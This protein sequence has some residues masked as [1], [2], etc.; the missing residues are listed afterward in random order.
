MY[1]SSR[2]MEYHTMTTTRTRARARS[3]QSTRYTHRGA[4]GRDRHSPGP[5]SPLL[6]LGP[7]TP[8]RADPVSGLV[9]SLEKGRDPSISAVR[10]RKVSLAPSVT[11][12]HPPLRRSQGAVEDGGWPLQR[13]ETPW[14]T[15]TRFAGHVFQQIAGFLGR[16]VIP[17]ASGHLGG[18]RPRHQS[19]L[20]LHT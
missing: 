18:R 6:I 13:G 16:S 8:S 4:E 14:T 9:L 17:A 1:L 15:L 3:F 11:L 12:Y 2:E 7:A 5:P 10:I 20:C 19:R